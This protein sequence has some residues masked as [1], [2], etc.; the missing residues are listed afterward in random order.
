[1]CCPWLWWT[2]P[3]CSS[4]MWAS[5]RGENQVCR[6]YFF[7]IFL[8]ELCP[9]CHRLCQPWLASFL[10]SLWLSFTKTWKDE[11]SKI[12]GDWSESQY[13]QHSSFIPN[14][15]SRNVICRHCNDS[16][17]WSEECISPGNAL[18]PGSAT[19]A[20]PAGSSVEALLPGLWTFCCSLIRHR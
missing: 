15:P 6:L 5:L 13:C 8:A 3:G 19:S 12:T 9:L 4:E 20:L 11:W 1:M 7:L 18:A 16:L 14:N 17:H 10:F 2:L